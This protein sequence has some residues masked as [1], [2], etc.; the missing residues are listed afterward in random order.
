MK[1]HRLILGRH[2]RGLAHTGVDR[3]PDGWVLDLREATRS[4][5]QNDALHAL[6]RQIHKQRPI[7]NG[8][9]MTEELWK[10]TFLDALSTEMKML[11][12]LDGDGFF[13]ATRRSSHLT[14]TEFNDLLTI[15]LAWCARAGLTVKHFDEEPSPT[16]DSR[17]PKKL[18]AEVA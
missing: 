3:A 14:K 1:R 12:K 8:Q 2:N 18:A 4:D 16:Q 5:R 17:Q 15:I 7:H 10:E 9:R 6:I 13:P 11:P